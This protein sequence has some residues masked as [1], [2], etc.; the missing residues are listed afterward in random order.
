MCNINIL[1]IYLNK[2]V[3]KSKFSHNDSNDILQNL[4][5][6]KMESIIKEFLNF[7]D[8]SNLKFG[9]QEDLKLTEEEMTLNQSELLRQQY[10]SL[11]NNQNNIEKQFINSI[12]KYIKIIKNLK[13]K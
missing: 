9:L 3:S 5:K 10:I 7:D 1:I 13:R 12:E 8:F 2:E 6:N 4:F 11:I